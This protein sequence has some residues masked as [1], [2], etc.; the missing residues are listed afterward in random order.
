V[1][2]AVATA[3]LRAA[4]WR[5]SGVIIN[6][7]CLSAADTR[8][9]IELLHRHFEFI[10]HGDLLA[11][12]SRRGRKPFCL[13]TFDDGKRN[14]ATSVAPV[15]ERL[16]VPAVFY[17]TT[18]FVESGTPLWFDRYDLLARDRALPAGLSRDVVKQLPLP[19]L[20]ER[21]D[22]ACSAAT[23]ACD[24]DDED[25]AP[26]SRD[27]VI[28]LAAKGFTIG[29]HTVDHPVLTCIGE[30]EARA[31]V[32]RSIR[33]IREWVGACPSF[34]FT[35]GNYTARLAQH[36]LACGVETAVTTE[37]VWASAAF[38]RWRLPRIQL[39]P[40]QTAAKVQL[41]LAAGAAGVLRN[42]DGSGRLYRRVQRLQRRERPEVDALAGSAPSSPSPHLAPGAR[43]SNA[44]HG[45]A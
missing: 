13:L 8:A 34:A 19:V 39:H 11:R 27:E 16:G 7:H 42:P 15:L 21:L 17:V 29:A 24:L 45:E 10:H 12:L 1:L 20:R 6:E 37:P 35:N 40:G 9:R 3:L 4:S 30:S 22:R 14:N 32:A 31:Q 44:P 36:A 5:T 25:V 33:A 26:M 28:A 23:I 2:N 41:K 38:P 18:G 43:R